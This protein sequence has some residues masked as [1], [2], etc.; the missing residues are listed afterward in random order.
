MR[1]R[2]GRVQRGVGTHVWR[3]GAGLGRIGMQAW[4]VGAGLGRARA[5][6]RCIEIG[7][8]TFARGQI[9]TPFAAGS[10]LVVPYRHQLWLGRHN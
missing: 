10:V 8:R 1:V 4:R 7:F 6:L 5:P 9:G 2:F 3:V